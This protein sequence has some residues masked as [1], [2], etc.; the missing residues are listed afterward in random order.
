MQNS[1]FPGKIDFF[2]KKW[3]SEAVL[4]TQNR[5]S[6]LLPSSKSLSF[7]FQML[8]ETFAR[9]GC[10]PPV[11]P[12]IEFFS[13]KQ[14]FF[15]QF[16]ALLGPTCRCLPPCSLLTLLL[17]CVWKSRLPGR[18]VKESLLLHLGCCCLKKCFLLMCATQLHKHPQNFLTAW[19][20]HVGKRVQTRKELLLFSN[21]NAPIAQR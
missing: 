13:R 15:P 5:S 19:R 12:R 14:A 16:I 6:S 7:K 20:Q 8:V 11:L 21:K 2:K 9:L 18:E 1:A 17:A 4:C 10:A 3:I